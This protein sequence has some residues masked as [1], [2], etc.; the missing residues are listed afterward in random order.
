[1]IALEN[2]NYNDQQFNRHHFHDIYTKLHYKGHQK[3]P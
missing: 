2:Y 1:M 3:H